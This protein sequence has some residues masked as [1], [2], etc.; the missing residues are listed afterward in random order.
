MKS[1]EST[2]FLL[3]KS[4]ASAQPLASTLVANQKAN[5]AFALYG[6]ILITGHCS[7]ISVRIKY[8]FRFSYGSLDDEE[9]NLI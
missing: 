9:L 7:A 6:S 4:A 2:E 5:K 3:N 1:E 8:L